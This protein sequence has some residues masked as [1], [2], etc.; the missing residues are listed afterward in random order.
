MTKMLENGMILEAYIMSPIYRR[1]VY[2]VAGI[3]M[4]QIYLLT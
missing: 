3:E 1:S 2:A 4:A